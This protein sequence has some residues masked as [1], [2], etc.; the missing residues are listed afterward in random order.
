MDDAL[1]AQLEALLLTLDTEVRLL[2]ASGQ[3]LIP[4][5]MQAYYLPDDL[6]AGQTQRQH[7]YAFQRV[8]DEEGY[9]LVTR[10]S[11]QAEDLLRLSG[12]A[13]RSLIMLQ[14]P[15]D[16]M[17]SAFLRLL[18]EEM[19]EPDSAALMKKY[20]IQPGVPRQVLLLSLP[21]APGGSAFR[22]LRDL[23][24][25]EEGD[26][27]LDYSKRLTALVKALE[28]DPDSEETEEF[29]L[30]MQETVS[31]ELGLGLFCGVGNPAH[32]MEE[33]RES[34]AQAELALEIGPRYLP[35]ER[36]FVWRK[37]LLPRFLSEIPPERAQRYH[38]LLFNKQTASLFTE[39]MLET[40]TMFLSKDLNLSDTARQLYIHR[41]TLVY[42]LDKVQRLSG[43]DLRR[44]D[45]A[46]V[47][48]LLYE[49]RRN[50]RPRGQ[51]TST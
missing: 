47:F 39:E 14:P 4:A 46:F 45:D 28:E 40:V 29:V 10:E 49:L 51:R 37:L 3:S 20:R 17:P 42:R 18:T 36:V 11:P 22:M 50:L 32:S 1:R 48:R 21:G 34:F 8:M 6:T 38:G 44:F 41:N 25:L 5:G 23:V 12:A 35:K 19:P 2:D 27:L 26:Q 15:K 24:P 30:A 13:V 9:V 43:L 33:L 31:Q 16:D 7:G